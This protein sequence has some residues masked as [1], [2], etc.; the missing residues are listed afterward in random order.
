MEFPN[1]WFKEREKKYGNKLNT[2]FSNGCSAGKETGPM[3]IVMRGYLGWS[4]QG[5]FLREGG[6]LGRLLTS[7]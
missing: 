2:K 5:E 6:W 7:A 1:F 4:G 3:T